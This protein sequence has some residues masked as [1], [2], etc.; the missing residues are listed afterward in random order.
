M[1]FQ[2]MQDV[3]NKNGNLMMRN[4]CMLG[5]ANLHTSRLKYE[6]YSY[7]QIDS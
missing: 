3:L 2:L 5:D 4:A 7:K 6:K 1:I